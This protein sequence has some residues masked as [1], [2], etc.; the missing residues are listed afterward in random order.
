MP[1]P[2]ELLSRCCQYDAVATLML[3]TTQVRKRSGVV[4]LFLLQR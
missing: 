3:Q 1:L 4:W 2:T